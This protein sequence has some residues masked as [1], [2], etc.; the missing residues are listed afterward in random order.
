MANRSDNF[1]RANGSLNGS[2]P[3]DSGSTWTCT[4]GGSVTSN[5]FQHS[6]GI[7]EC[8]TLEASSADVDVQATLTVSPPSLGRAGLIARFVDS[9][10]FWFV[11]IRAGTNTGKILK[12]VAGTSS[13]VA[14]STLTPANGDVFRFNAQGDRLRLYQN[15]VLRAD[16]GTGQTF[17]QTATKHGLGLEAANTTARWDDFSITDLSSPSFDVK[18]ASGFL[19]FL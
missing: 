19:A 15:G 5:E 8:N 12:R 7:P 10:N 14:T 13:Q 11:E 16:T 4:T 17:N 3:S 18:K 1:N 2:T 9:N 6:G